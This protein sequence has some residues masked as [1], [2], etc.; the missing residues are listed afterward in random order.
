MIIISNTTPLHYLIIIGEVEILHQLFGQVIVP[1]AVMAELQ[2]QQT[3]AHVRNWISNRPA[4]LD[5][6]SPSILDSTLRLGA[7]ESEAISLAEELK[8]DQILLDDKKA[9]KAALARGLPV[10]G[11]L[12]LLEIA[13]ERGLINLAEAI[14]RLRKTTFRAPAQAIEEILRRDAER[15]K[16][17][18]AETTEHKS[19]LSNEADG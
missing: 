10:T 8:A 19:G 16:G 3:P 5:V 1:Q 17:Q 6:R 4:W 2:H 7:G 12:T 9:R 14:D 18:G 15:R 11:T 13:G